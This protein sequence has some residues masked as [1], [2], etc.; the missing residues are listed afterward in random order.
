[1]TLTVTDLGCTLTATTQ[2]YVRELI[3]NSNSPLAEGSNLHLISG[4]NFN[5]IT[6]YD[7]SWAGPNG[8]T[9][10]LPYPVLENVLA[11]QSGTYTLT[12]TTNIC[13]T[14][15]MI[16]ININPLATISNN[17]PI[18]AGDELNF[19]V[20]PDNNISGTAGVFDIN[21]LQYIESSN[22]N[23]PSDNFTIEMWIKTTQSDG[24]LFYNGDV[25]LSN[26]AD[27]HIFIEDGYLKTRILP[28]AEP[29]LNSGVLVN[30]NNWHHVAVT[31]KSE[32]NEGTKIFVDGTLAIQSPNSNTCINA[33]NIYIGVE[34]NLSWSDGN[35]IRYYDG[36]MDNV[37]IWNVAKSA[38]E[39]QNGM[40]AEVSNAPDLVYIQKFNNSIN[41]FKGGAPNGIAYSN[42]NI[43]Y[44]FTYS[45]AGPNGFTSSAQN[46]SIT[47][48]EANQSGLYTL[49][50]EAGGNQSVL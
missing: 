37:K 21:S 44:P 46:P 27:K 38:V 8:F 45:W 5:D 10:D 13:V 34:R 18:C 26:Y 29:G 25:N 24:G 22:N 4:L 6:I 11:S 35:Y 15:A 42:A 49:T 9:S 3:I 7:Y 50:V 14:T 41:E 17:T 23:F 40:Y 12:A 33:P 28:F 30:D 19:T 16:N 48:T 47:D 31:Q 1:Y 39:I 36:L 43:P 32:N 20:L 2:I